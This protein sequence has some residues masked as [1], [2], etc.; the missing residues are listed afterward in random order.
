VFE[1]GSADG[2]WSHW[3]DRG[4][5][6]G[7]DIFKDGSGT[8]R[9]WHANG[10]VSAEIT[11]YRGQMTGP[12]KYWE[13]DG[14][15]YGTKF[16]FEGRP[17]SKKRYLELCNADPKLPR[18]VDQ[19]KTNT[20][21]NY[22]RQLRKEKRAKAKLGPTEE[23]LEADARFD[24]QCVAESKSPGGKEVIVWL[25]S[26]KRGQRELGELGRT[27]ALKLAK[28]LYA[29]GAV[30]VWAARIEH[31]EDGFEC[32]RRLIVKLPPNADK[33]SEIY[34]LCSDP[35]RPSLATGMPAVRFGRQFM[36]VSLL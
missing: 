28:K 36:S 23:D 27:Q 11:Y 6:L 5:L 2:E 20:F 35:A 15:L 25:E 8:S 14:M 18:Y 19:K 1:N 26:G 13:Q 21:G 33:R 7:T 10:A 32:S 17:I 9:Q 12:M 30:K 31:D 4:D 3:N 16:F 29:F 34:K 22:V 24:E